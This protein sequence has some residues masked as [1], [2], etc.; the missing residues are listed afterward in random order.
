[1]ARDR[2]GGEGDHGRRLDGCHLVCGEHIVGGGHS[3][4]DQVGHGIRD[5]FSN[6]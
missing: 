5:R 1:M 6:L 3:A 4:G 2:A